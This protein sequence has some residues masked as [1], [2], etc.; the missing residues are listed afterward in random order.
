MNVLKGIRVLAPPWGDLAFWDVSG[1]HGA[2]LAQISVSGTSWL[3]GRFAHVFVLGA[4]R[5][6]ARPWA[7]LGTPLAGMVPGSLRCLF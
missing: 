2:R 5:V 3:A 6:L 1:R 7:D 4:I